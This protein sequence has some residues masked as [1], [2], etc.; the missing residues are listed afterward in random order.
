MSPIDDSD[1]DGDWDEN[2]PFGDTVHFPIRDEIDLHGLPPR[3]IPELVSSY[4]DEAKAH[5]FS[6][7][8]IV[9][10]KG[11]GVQRDIVRRLLERSKIVEAFDDA[12][13]ERGGWGATMVRFIQVP[14]A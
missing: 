2:N 4:L 12:P 8:R 6:V 10:G 13:A 5:G 14:R 7:V 11:E 1:D 3:L 9:H